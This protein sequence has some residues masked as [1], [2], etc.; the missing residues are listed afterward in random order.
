MANATASPPK[1]ELLEHNLRLQFPFEEEPGLVR[2]SNP[3]MCYALSIMC[4]YAQT[5]N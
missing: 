4:T 2:G 5:R 1:R 3:L